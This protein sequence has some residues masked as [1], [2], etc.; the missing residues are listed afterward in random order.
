MSIEKETLRRVQEGLFHLQRGLTPFVTSRMKAVHG[1]RWLH[2]ASRAMGA[3]PSSALDAYGL[4][5]TMLDLW[6]EVFDESFP[7]NEKHRVRNFTSTALEAR[8]ATAHLSIP[9]QDDEALRYLDA[10]HQLLR[11][12]K[13]PEHEVL[14]LRKLYETQR[15]HGVAPAR[16]PQAY[17][18][19]P[20]LDLAPPPAQT[21]S[22]KTLRP[23]IEVALPHPDVLAN[24]FKE[25]EFAAD[26]FAVDAGHATE[27]YGMA[28]SFFRITYLTEGL[29][30]VLTS[31]LQRLSGKGGDPI[32]G[33]Q[34]AFGGGKTHTML[35]VY[36]LA[37]SAQLDHLE[38]VGQLFK[39]AGLTGWKKPQVAVFVGSSKGTDTSLILQ[40]GPK[41]HTLWGY[42][43][44]RLAGERGLKIVAEAEAART[45]PGSELMVEVLKLAGPSVILLDELV[46]Y[47]RQLPD[48]RFEAF[49]SFIQSLTEAVKIAPN[50]LLVGSLPEANTEA[51]GDK[52]VEAL[53]RL[54]KVFGRVQSP[55][56]PASGDETYEIIRRRL[57]QTLDSDG[58]RARD[59]TVKAF[60]DL[61]KKNAAEFPPEVREARYYDLLRMSY[62]I[63]P[64]LFDRLSKD[65]ASLDKFQRTR[66]VLRFMANV[67]GVLWH[68]RVPDPLIMPARVPVANDRIRASVLYPLDPAFGAIVDREVDGEGALPSQIEANPQ[69]R[70]SQARAATRAARAV[71]LCSAPL[72]GHPNAGIGA[73]ALRLACAEPGDQLAI[74][75]EALNELKQRAAYL[76][77][78]AG[79]F[80]FSTQPTLNRVAEDRAKAYPDHEVDGAIAR[81]L[82]E[83]AATKGGFHRV[84]ATPDD[85]TTI[86]E[87]DALSLV[88]LGSSTPHVGKGTAKSAATDAVTDALTRCRASQRRLRNTLLFVAPDEAHLATARESVRRSMAWASIVADDKL[89]QQLTQA[90]ATDAKDKAKTSREGAQKAVR[91][92]W[93]H[94]LYPIK[95]AD[96]EIGKA[97]DLEHLAVSGRDK[98]AIPQVV[99]DKARGDGVA[100]ET[101]GAE[102]LWRHVKPLW[103][104]N[105]AH[106]AVNEMVEWFAS[107]VYL[108]KLRDRVVLEQA[109]KDALGKLDPMFGYAENYDAASDTYQT[110]I[111]AKSPPEFF[112]PA[113]V[114]VRKEVALDRLR[115]APRPGTAAPGAGGATP[116]A[117][118]GS[119]TP[120]EPKPTGPVKPRRFYGSVEIDASNRPVNAFGKIVES[121]IMEL[122]RTKG[123]KV[124]LTLEIEAEA[125]DGFD[126]NDVGVVRDNTKQ[127]KF[128]PGSTGFS[129]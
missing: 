70:I 14:E 129:E 45:N 109:I 11:A 34:T 82:Q 120:E 90:Q 57:F 1:E 92:A 106:L 5:K 37:K 19:A 104:E 38:G 29:R 27:D 23:W 112:G 119:R 21:A 8:N 125:P 68:D 78:E 28:E 36:H 4:V 101:L 76:Y 18:A 124:K 73:P 62:P 7:R 20:K 15:N 105:R 115:D 9:L 48:D 122:Q 95:N 65:W 69:R 26:L 59:E 121:V 55:W 61:Y 47:A 99:Y 41:V 22:G 39:A 117:P 128:T 42:I 102:S 89:Q 31:S 126:E 66:G 12:V 51:G 13:A 81:L 127:L 72:V 30:R 118:T 49:L 64:E 67:V 74:F 85:A 53:A 113:A 103:P 111:F 6:R 123:T 43:A 79:R 114:L 83:D 33:L 63:H 52:G 88:I 100:M 54:E 86:D 97:F 24:R 108:P 10:M 116:D 58:E 98:S 3:A 87:A 17:P 94:V 25:A 32:I 77:E 60:H 44:W 84:F 50:A 71:F 96:T 35:A 110:L 40:N 56:M 75:G 16:S 80:W 93:S 107:Y 46:A 91:N 2:Y